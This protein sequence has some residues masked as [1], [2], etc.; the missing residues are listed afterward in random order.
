MLKSLLKI[1]R[2]HI[3]YANGFGEQKGPSVGLDDLVQRG[4][5]RVLDVAQAEQA[6]RL[7]FGQEVW[8]VDL[9]PSNLER[10]AKVLIVLEKVS[11]CNRNKK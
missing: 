5:E 1:I 2:C 4:G 8:N 11:C 10:L 9:S 6:K 7:V 3:S